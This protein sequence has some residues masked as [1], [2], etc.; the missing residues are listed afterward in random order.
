M[1]E[2]SPSVLE[3]TGPPTDNQRM[4]MRNERGVVVSW[5]VKMLL[6]LAIGG[7]I[8]FDAG[9][10]AMNFF[11]LDSAA[12]EVANQIATDVATGSTQASDLNALKTCGRKPSSQPLCQELQNKVK[13]HDAKLLKVTVDLENN[14]KIRMRRTASTLVVSRIGF[15]E[16]WGTATAEGRASTETQ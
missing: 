8:I 3:I 14:L 15:I 6:G 4:M 1:W 2:T 10:I 5:L 9:S 12:D 16:D 11:G 7:V 13:Q